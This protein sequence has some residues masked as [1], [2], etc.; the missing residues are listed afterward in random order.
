MHMRMQRSYRL[1]LLRAYFRGTVMIDDRLPHKVNRLPDTSCTVN[2]AS[3]CYNV[4]RA[5]MSTVK[6]FANTASGSE[7]VAT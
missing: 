3:E 1:K 5:W 2:A 4:L 7:T 6:P